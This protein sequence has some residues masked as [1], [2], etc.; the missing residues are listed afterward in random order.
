MR[1]LKTAAAVLAPLSLLAAGCSASG[2]DTNGPTIAAAFYPL[3]FVAEQVAGDHAE[4]ELLTQPGGEPHDLELGVTETAI[5]TSAD[6]VVYER[7]FQPAVDTA[8]EN[9]AEGAALDAAEVVDL[10][11]ADESEEEHAEHAEDEHAVEDD[12]G[13]ADGDHDPHFWL[14]PLRMA[15]LADAVADE[16]VEIDP[17]NAESYR[18][19]AAELRVELEELDGEF[20][21][22]LGECARDTVVVSHDAFSYLE[23]YGVH[24]APIAGLSPDAEPT[25]AH[26]GELQ[27]LIRDEG[28]TT[29]F[30]ERLASPALTE[31]LASDL[32]ISTAVLDPIEGLTAETEGED[33]LSL[34]RSNLSALREANGCR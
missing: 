19:N 8:V 16:L 15:T 22:G 20:A 28:I 11:L 12:H 24:I 1:P 7:E 14:D 27:E 31:T 29:V 10:L 3:H 5:V 33:Y 34:M 4:V 25:P 26:L 30:S 18:D 23:K 13:H 17:D 9:N 6:L 32:G 2:D 21:T